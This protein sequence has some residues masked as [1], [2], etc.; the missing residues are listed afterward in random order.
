MNH[1]ERPGTSATPAAKEP[2]P[3][4]RAGMPVRT[5]RPE[6][7]SRFGQRSARFSIWT[8]ATAILI[9]AA[10]LLTYHTVR[11]NGRRDYVE[12]LRQMQEANDRER[13]EL[14]S[15][16]DPLT[17]L[18][19]YLQ[20]HSYYADTMNEQKMLAKALKAYVAGIGDPYAAWYTEE[21][22]KTVSEKNAGSY[23]GI[24]VTVE[25][26]LFRIQSGDE[27]IDTLRVKKIEPGSPA[28][29]AGIKKGDLLYAVQDE[30]TGKLQTLGELGRDA[31]I[32]AIRGVPGTTVELWWFR[33]SG[34]AYESRSFSCTRAMIES[35]SV[36]GEMAES[37]PEIGVV[38]IRNFELITPK[39]FREAVDSCLERGAKAFIFD[40]RENPGG[41]LRSIR[42]VL[43]FFLQEGELVIETRDKD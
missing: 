34:D 18:H 36:T 6:K 40:V 41:D 25:N 28:E 19:E 1:D 16:T 13:N 15:S 10:I 4:K 32:D 12:K 43:S 2:S 24:G 29:Q 27:S 39:Q 7:E 26:D 14:A 22:Y 8:A 20:A 5:E 23:A 33:E 35:V 38:R 3:G 42:A 21:D 17:Y 37:A 30:E 11:E 9:L 31:F